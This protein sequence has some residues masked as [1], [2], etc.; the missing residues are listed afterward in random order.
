MVSLQ[1]GL[2]RYRSHFG[3]RYPLGPMRSAQ[4][5]YGNPLVRIW[6]ASKLPVWYTHPAWGRATSFCLGVQ[7][8]QCQ[9]LVHQTAGR[10]ISSLSGLTRYRSHFGSRYPLGPM[11]SAQA[12]YGNPLVRIW[13]ASKLPV[14]YTHPAW[15]RATSFCLGVQETQCQNLVHQTAGRN[16]SSL[17]G[18]TRYR[19]F[20]RET[21]TRNGAT[22]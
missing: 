17:S 21:H 9:N 11:R 8:T 12:F 20:K 16:I 22:S 1:I 7:E 10:N 5:F 4:A 13:A 19:G 2:T 6:A 3:S 15:G 14:W 18:L